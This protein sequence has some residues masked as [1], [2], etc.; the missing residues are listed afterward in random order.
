MFIVLKPLCHL[1][2][3]LSYFCDL[4]LQ[5]ADLIPNSFRVRT[6]MPFNCCFLSLFLLGIV[7][8]HLLFLDT[9]LARIYL[10]ECESLLVTLV[11]V[12]LKDLVI[13]LD[14]FRLGLCCHSY[15]FMEMF[16]L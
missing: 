7:Y 16:V 2:T 8:L 15:S 1:V 5:Y 12:H 9:S 11:F 10:W 3:F 13:C 14:C 6:I 4:L